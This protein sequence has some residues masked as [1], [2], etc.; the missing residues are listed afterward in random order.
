[1]LPGRV[2]IFGLE[3]T[4][5]AARGRRSEHQGRLQGDRGGARAHRAL[6]R[7]GGRRPPLL[8]RHEAGGRGARP[9]PRHAARH[10]HR[11][12]HARPSCSSRVGTA[13]SVNVIAAGRPLGARRL[14]RLGLGARPAVPGGLPGGRPRRPAAAA[15]P[16]RA[17][18]AAPVRAVAPARAAAG[19]GGG[20]GPRRAGGLERGAG[21]AGAAPAAAASSAA[22]S[23]L[24]T[25]ATSSSAWAASSRPSSS[26]APRWRRSCSVEGGPAV[27]PVTKAPIPFPN[28]DSPVKPVPGT[29]PE[30]TPV[31][32]HYRVDIDLTPPSIDAAVVAAAHLRARRAPA[33][34]HPRPDQERLRGARPVHH[35][36]VH[37][38][39]GGRAAHRH[40]PLERP[41]LPRR[42]RKRAAAAVRALRARARP[43]RLRR[44]RRTR[45]DPVRPPGDPRLRLER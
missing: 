14:R 34:A 33:A 12:P 44:G 2:V 35:A 8:R 13:R 3:T 30:Y 27:A 25:A 17:G 26:S 23:R 43:G 32:E 45:D 7:L 15:A 39:P 41:L 9:A 42:A 6:R 19:A 20:G 10:R 22:L 37:L 4:L 40:D 1:M 31:A 5:H 18:R 38:Q 11:R 28:A 29:R 16:R 36:G 24:R 21:P